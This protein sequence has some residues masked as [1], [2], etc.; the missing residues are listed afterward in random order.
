MVLNSCQGA[1]FES[2]S[3]SHFTETDP[4]SGKLISASSLNSLISPIVRTPTF[5][6]ELYILVG[7]R[8]V[9]WGVSSGK[10]GEGSKSSIMSFYYGK[11]CPIL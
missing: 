4:T 6:S 9:S 10:S 8:T 7:N 3:R 5:V 2:F 1:F 11:R